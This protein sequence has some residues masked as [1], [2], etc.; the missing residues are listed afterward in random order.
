MR[1]LRSSD[2]WFYWHSCES[3][4]YARHR[5]LYVNIGSKYIS[6]WEGLLQYK[7][8]VAPEEES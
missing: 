4:K 8:E 1:L 6:I 3:V 7:L 2:E 5:D